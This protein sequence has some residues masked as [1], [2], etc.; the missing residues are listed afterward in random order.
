VNASN[1]V[2][3]SFVALGLAWSATNA[4]SQEPASG[5]GDALSAE[6]VSRGRY[7]VLVSHCNNCHTA[8]YATREG[9]VPEAKWLMGN[10]V[11]WRGRAGTVYAINLRAFME[12]LSEQDWL[13]VAREG[14]ARPPMP[15][16]SL[17]DTSDADLR[18]MYRY[19]RSLRPVGA[20]APGALPADQEPPPPYNQLPDMS[21][22]R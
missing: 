10:P 21:T 22:R 18:A 6:A 15:W 19:I 20:P 5:A 7:V 16:W 11:G 14:R 13:R 1:V 12:N 8:G 9:D 2:A 3:S 4:L 17:R